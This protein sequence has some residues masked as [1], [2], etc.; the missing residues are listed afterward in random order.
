MKG[1]WMTNEVKATAQSKESSAA[2]NQLNPQTENSRDEAKVEFYKHV[3][4]LRREIR[5]QA[6]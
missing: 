1:K 4:A 5:M 2:N 3:Q 6:K